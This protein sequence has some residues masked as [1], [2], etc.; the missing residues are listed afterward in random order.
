MQYMD[1]IAS[2]HKDRRTTFRKRVLYVIKDE[3]TRDGEFKYINRRRHAYALLTT[4]ALL[5]LSQAII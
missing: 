5:L 3:E 1:I 2:T 4:A